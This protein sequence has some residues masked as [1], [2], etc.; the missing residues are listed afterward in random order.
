MPRPCVTWEQKIPSILRASVESGFQGMVF[1]V[2]LSIELTHR[3]RVM[4]CTY[5][6]MRRPTTKEYPNKFMMVTSPNNKT[7]IYLC[8]LKVT[9]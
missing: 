8:S 9:L 1:F 5:C 2:V 7:A 4:V 3:G 6:L